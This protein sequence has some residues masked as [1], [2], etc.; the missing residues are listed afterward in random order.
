MAFQPAPVLR[1]DV[2]AFYA[3]KHVFLTG[4][5]GFVGKARSSLQSALT[6]QVYLEK[7]LR[8]CPDIAGIFILIRGKKSVPASERLAKLLADD[9]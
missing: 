4:A 7:L 8:S 6:S 3:G 1:S 5:T 2:Q 9:V